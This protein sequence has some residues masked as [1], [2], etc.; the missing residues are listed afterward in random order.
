MKS[1]LLKTLTIDHYPFDPHYAKELRAFFGERFLRELEADEKRELQYTTFCPLL[2][3]NRSGSNI[4]I[5]SLHQA[6]LGFSEH[7][8]PMNLPSIERISVRHG[9]ETFTDYFLFLVRRWRKQ[10]LAGFKI[11]IGQLFDLS[12][13]GL[14]DPFK[15]IKLLHSIRRDRVAQAVSHYIAKESGKWSSKEGEADTVIPY[16]AERILQFLRRNARQSADYELYK[17]I[18]Q[19]EALEIVFEEFIQDPKA[20]VSEVARFLSQA[21]DL[22]AVDLASAVTAPQA[23]PLGETFAQ[24][25]REEMRRSPPALAM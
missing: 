10:E 22:E 15:E 19:V 17:T 9:L 6:G 20:R 8:E 13:T 3:G 4:L 1:E 23:N 24:R 12:R 14:L 21:V 25:F 2:F 7:G 18:H 11:S 16:S 5:H